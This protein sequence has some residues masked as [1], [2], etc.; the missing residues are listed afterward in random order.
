MRSDEF[1]RCGKCLLADG[2][3][4]VGEGR[5]GGSPDCL[6]VLFRDYPQWIDPTHYPAYLP[7]VRQPDN[8]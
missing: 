7:H 8:L 6:S 5:E 1:S 4:Y 2:D 3:K